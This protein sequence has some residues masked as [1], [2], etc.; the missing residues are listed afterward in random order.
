VPLLHDP[1]IFDLGAPTPRHPA[2]APLPMSLWRQA[3]L[4][5]LCLFAFSASLSKRS[6]DPELAEGLLF[7]LALTLLRAD[8]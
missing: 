7:L 6:E 5:L 3:G 2:P 1:E 4:S 8:S